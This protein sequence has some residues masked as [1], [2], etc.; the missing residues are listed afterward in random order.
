MDRTFTKSNPA[1][2]WMKDQFIQTKTMYVL[3]SGITCFVTGYT[4]RLVLELIPIV[5]MTPTFS[6]ILSAILKSSSWNLYEC[7]FLINKKF[8]ILCN[9]YISKVYLNYVYCFF[10]F[11]KLLFSAL[12]KETILFRFKRSLILWTIIPFIS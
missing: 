3:T 1:K 12:E 4:V 2:A 6:I 8:K 5:E 9:S 7:V 10:I 11:I